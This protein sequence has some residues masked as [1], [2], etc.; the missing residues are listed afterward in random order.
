MPPRHALRSRRPKTRERW[1]ARGI[2]T[3]DRVGVNGLDHLARCPLTEQSH[4]TICENGTIRRVA[5]IDEGYRPTVVVN[6]VVWDNNI[7]P[8]FTTNM[9]EGPWTPNW[10]TIQRYTSDRERIR[11]A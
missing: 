9:G 1:K 11:T 5:D 3:S 4:S 7:V 6:D 2:N 8:F 10:V